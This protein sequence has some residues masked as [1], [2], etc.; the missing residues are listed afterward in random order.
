MK[1]M[2]SD[3]FTEA[4]K[5]L[6][7]LYAASPEKIEELKNLLQSYGIDK[8]FESKISNRLAGIQK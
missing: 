1:E 6:A 8:Q 7:D 4:E 2:K 3:L 5:S